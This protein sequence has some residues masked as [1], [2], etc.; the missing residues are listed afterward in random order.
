MRALVR[1]YAPRVNLYV[2]SVPD[3][4]LEGVARDLAEALGGARSSSDRDPRIAVMHTS[5]ATSTAV[6]AACAD[7]GCLTLSFH[8]LQTFSDPA[9]GVDRL[10]GTTVAVTPG[11]GDDPEEA[12][13]LAERIARALG[14]TAFR[15]GEEHRVLY[16]TAATM[17]S[18]YLVTLA[19]VAENLL[20]AAGF[21]REAALPGLLPL[22]RGAVDNLTNQG[23]VAALTGP[24]SRGDTETVAAHLSALARDFPTVSMLY[25]EL[26][27]ATLDIVRDRHEI[28]PETIDQLAHQLTPDPARR[29]QP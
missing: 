6:L 28:A 21:P 10:P 17:A 14:V 20:C 16:H 2:L 25:R 13:R 22:M 29:R 9:T 15:L 19:N 26:G 7:W 1:A 12:W 3:A 8:P 27:L 24:L 11:P 5:G 4:A 18:N 23:S